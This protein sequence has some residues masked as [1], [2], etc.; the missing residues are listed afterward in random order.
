M[1]RSHSIAAL[2]LVCI[3]ASAAHAQPGILIYDNGPFITGNG[4][5]VCMESASSTN[6]SSPATGTT[7]GAA[8]Y[9]VIG[10]VVDDFT[11][12]GGESW[13]VETLR[14]RAYQPGTPYD[15]Q[16]ST[17]YVRVWATNPQLG[18][19]PI[20][21][22]F[23]T[24]RHLN[25][26]FSGIYRTGN[27]ALT[28]CVRAIKNVDIDLSDLPSLPPGQYWVEVGLESEEAGGIFSPP[29]EPRQPTDN[30]LEIDFSGIAQPILDGG[31]NEALE[32][33]FQL[34]G[35][36]EAVPLRACLTAG[37]Q[38]IDA[39][40]VDCTTIHGG[41][42]SYLHACAE[43]GACCNHADGT[44][45]E[46]IA[47]EACAS[48]GL[49]FNVGA[50]CASIP[51]CGQT[52]GACC[53]PDNTPT[54]CQNL[55]R[56]VNCTA[57]GG[58]WHPGSCSSVA[59]NDACE[60]ATTVFEGS[61]PFDNLGYGTDGP[62]TPNDCGNS[63]FV[64][65]AD[66]WF[67]Y[68]STL[69]NPGGRI[70]F[71]LC[72]TTSFDTTMQIYRTG[73]GTLCD[74]LSAT[75]LEVFCDDDGCGDAGGASYLSIPA[76]PNDT[77][78]IRI[79]GFDGAEGGG[80]LRITQ[81]ESGIGACCSI[82][83]P[84]RIVDAL[85]CDF[86][87]E[88]FT[89]GVLCDSPGFSC[90]AVGACCYG[91]FGCQIELQDLCEQS[92]GVFLG[93]GVD[94]GANSD[95]DNDGE[96]DR[97]AIA[98]W[99][100]DCNA[101]GIPDSCDVSP[102]GAATDCDGNFIPDICQ[103]PSRCCPG[104]VNADAQLDGH[105]IQS[106]LSAMFDGPQTC[107]TRHFCRLDVN[108]DFRFDAADLNAL[109]DALLLGNDCPL[110]I[111]VTGRVDTINESGQ[112]VGNENQVFVL[113]GAG[114]LLYTYDQ[115]PNAYQDAWGYRDGASD[116]NYVYFG[117]IGGV[118]RHEADGSGGVQII[119]GPVPVT[120]GTWRA[121]AFDPTGD[122]GNGSLW[123][124]SFG[125]DLVETDLFGNLLNIFPNDLNLYGLAY[126]R[127]TGMLWGHHIE[128]PDF[129]AVMVEIDPANG[130]PT[131]ASFLSHF[132]VP[133]G[134]LNGVAQYGG[135][136]MDPR[137]NTIYGLLQGSPEDAIFHCDTS[138]NLISTFPTN[139]RADL[140]AQTGTI[141]NL[142]IAVVRP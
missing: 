3:L 140:N 106:F 9:W 63:P 51:N 112:I 81:I 58:Y 55:S 56:G 94:C 72:A 109:V 14:W 20:W 6:T 7:G 125:S 62:L 32:M 92:A 114:N 79:G 138:G 12:P 33:P 34:Y 105:D 103:A 83:Q 29:T 60:T 44:C 136:S 110:L 74:Q 87:T 76:N 30:A 118:A 1:T 21:G 86:G 10:R 101:N 25:T 48:E 47:P 104:D 135:A 78:L 90:P 54:H 18:G 132:G 99:A 43:L 128:G 77:F 64:G 131:G 45:E 59:C 65:Y 117:W 121:L 137:T 85:E 16:I 40:L 126:N 50:S 49:S 26:T 46:N 98:V 123:T 130:L 127:E 8:S 15:A 27:T 31:S 23:D 111:H 57:Q 139:P 95:C 39:T 91:V 108:E 41:V 107:F 133:G 17:A 80:M 113:D 2:T 97:C 115:V 13:N 134:S 84:C 129:D 102:G 93:D 96:S 71:S 142:G 82:D 69:E 141:R 67:A 116:G 19:E 100:P 88:L 4:V 89:D 38:C 5:D 122:N 119:S 37:G 28:S 61:T 120:G 75:A 66:A 35:A 22:D 53:Y 73:A 52:I 24:N 124:Q 36:A 11:V 68:T 70:E 42:W